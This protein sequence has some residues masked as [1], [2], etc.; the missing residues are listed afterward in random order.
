MCSENS[1][2]FK[3]ARADHLGL[4]SA[5]GIPLENVKEVLCLVFTN[6]THLRI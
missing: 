6:L 5:K 3:G 4:L 1:E 2:D